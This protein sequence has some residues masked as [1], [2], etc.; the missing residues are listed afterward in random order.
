M[1]DTHKITSATGLPTHK[2][3]YSF[4]KLERFGL[5][6]VSDPVTVERVTGGQ[7][8]V[9]DVKPVSLT[10]DGEKYLESSGR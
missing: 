1:D 6:Q 7:K 2:V 4:G 3:N 9:F 8:R 10:P 5:I